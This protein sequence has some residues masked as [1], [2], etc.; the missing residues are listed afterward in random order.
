MMNFK[1]IM[2]TLLVGSM[3]F[4]SLVGCGSK[5]QQASGGNSQAVGDGEVVKL[6]ALIVKHSLTKD[7]EEME[8]LKE[9]EEE[10][11]VQIEW[12]QISADWGQK[13]SALFGSG[14]IPDLL[15]NA[16]SDADYVQ[17]DGLFQDLTSLI[18]A[19]GN[20][21]STMFEEHPEVKALATS[22]EGKIYG[23]PSY[24]QQWANT[25]PLFINQTW[26][27]NLNLE[28]PTTWEELEKVLVAFKEQDANG[29]G[30]TTDEVP[31]DFAAL[32]DK[33]SPIYLLG[34]LG[35]PLSDDTGDGYFA[36]DGVVKN[37]F[38][39]ERFKV[40]VK[41]LNS[42]WSQGLINKET[43]TQD[44]SKYQSLARGEGDTAKVG[45]T[46]GWTASDR[47][48]NEIKDQ[49]VPVPPLKYTADQD[50]NEVSWMNSTNALSIKPNAVAMSA[51]CKNK[52][53]AMKFLNLFYDKT[54][55]IQVYYGGMNDIDK[56]I[57]DNGDGSYAVMA[58]A[59]SA[60]DPGTWK[61]TNT[62][63]DNGPYYIPDDLKLTLGKDM[64][65]VVEERKVYQE[66]LSR[67][68]GKNV[69]PQLF[70]KYSGD[71]ISTLAMNQ[72][73]INNITS[74]QIAAWITGE[75]DIES[76]WEQ[77]INNVKTVG[78]EEN[79]KIRQAAFDNYLSSL[80]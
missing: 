73:N 17:F 14:D 24:H 29:N 60:M 3:C 63:A 37:V 79:I 53:A 72:T 69:Y 25:R 52:D 32:P 30:D 31:M 5:E 67:V 38:V 10:A 28:M 48:G 58:P 43:F 34:S 18:E 36:E 74:Q 15:F 12:Q 76:E 6:S 16:T 21:I 65:D 8:W 1:K 26:L 57:K 49:Y 39:D 11:G 55:G 61:W 4:S 77:F 45:L 54:R 64:Q 50:I 68:N 75:G 78:L 44:Y 33:Y 62:F 27:D 70:M 13:K 47:F 46:W 22:V 56:G 41:Y 40:L 7:L 9:I 66:A 2:T 23:I 35:L 51:N 42:L 71:D 20:N 19:D 80:K 59:D